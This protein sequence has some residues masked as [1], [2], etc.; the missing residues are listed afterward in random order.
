M[1]EGDQRVPSH[2]STLGASAPADGA[3]EIPPRDKHTDSE[4]T[5]EARTTTAEA[6]NLK[7]KICT[8]TS[9]AQLI[10]SQIECDEETGRMFGDTLKKLPAALLP[11][12]SS[13]LVL[14]IKKSFGRRRLPNRGC[15][16]FAL[17]HFI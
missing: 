2:R 4:V 5:A 13:H 3:L 12:S 15:M 10:L 17:H 16:N 1:P 7:S 9:L 14:G 11:F 8:A 6:N